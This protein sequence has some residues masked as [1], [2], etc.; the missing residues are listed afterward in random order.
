[1]SMYSAKGV[2]AGCILMGDEVDDTG[3]V[4]LG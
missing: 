4:V 1:M 3:F 2:G